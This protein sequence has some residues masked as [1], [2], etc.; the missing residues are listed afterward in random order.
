MVSV[1][2]ISMGAGLF[3]CAMLVWLSWIDIKH[4]LL[5][6]LLTLPLMWAGLLIN[7]QEVFT[8]LPDAVLGAAV[9]YGVLWFA[10]TVYR[11]RAGQ[12]GMG[13]GDFKLMAAL[14]AWL[15]VGA[16]PWILTG[17]CVAG[18]IAACVWRFAGSIKAD[19]PFGPFLSAAGLAVMIKLFSS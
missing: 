16:V 2:M 6:D 15:G 13:Y 17:A 12:D 4:G 7:I 19:H 9:G 5:P 1:T 3:L 10:N 11:W 14:G 18:A 8:P